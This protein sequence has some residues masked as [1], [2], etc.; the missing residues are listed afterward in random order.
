[1]KIRIVSDCQGGTPLQHLATGA[2]VDLPVDEAAPLCLAG[3]AVL[4]D[5]NDRP[6]LVRHMRAMDDLA[7]R[8][9]GSRG[10]R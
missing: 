7:H 4:V 10:L 2:V 1:M 6:E 3:R 9:A 8:I 5:G